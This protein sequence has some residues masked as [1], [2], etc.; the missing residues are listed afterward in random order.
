MEQNCVMY[1]F[2]GDRWPKWFVGY[3]PL[4]GFREESY[5]FVIN[6]IVGT[7]YT[8]QK[9]NWMDESKWKDDPWSP[10]QL[11]EHGDF[12]VWYKSQYTPALPQFYSLGRILADGV[13]LTPLGI[14]SWIDYRKVSK[15][16][17]GTCLKVVEELHSWR[18]NFAQVL[19]PFWQAN[20]GYTIV[21]TQQANLGYSFRSHNSNTYNWKRQTD[22][23][24]LRNLP[25]FPRKIN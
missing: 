19:P 20:V 16:E 9:K 24:Q 4:S 21:T 11:P 14:Y 10:Y 5:I 7:S 23:S 22:G 18:R 13:I 6:F 17:A 1:M 3:D 15:R 12:T 25:I 2:L 8:D